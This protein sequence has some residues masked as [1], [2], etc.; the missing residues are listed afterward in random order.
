MQLNSVNVRLYPS[1]FRGNNFNPEAKLNTEEN[2]TS[3]V[4]RLS[5]RDGFVLSNTWV[6][7][8][9]GIDN[10]NT[11]IF[12]LHGY[13]FEISN[14]ASTLNSFS[15]KTSIY[16]HIRVGSM[17]SGNPDTG[18]TGYSA[19]VLT[20]I[21][22]GASTDPG[23]NQYAPGDVLD[24][25][26]DESDESY[27]FIGLELIDSLEGISTSSEDFYLL[28]LSRAST[29]DVWSVPTSSSIKFDLVD[30]SGGQLG[31]NEELS[32]ASQLITEFVKAKSTVITNLTDE[33]IT[34]IPSGK[35]L[36]SI[37]F[38]NNSN[39]YAEVTNTDNTITLQQYSSGKWNNASIAS[40]PVPSA[41][42]KGY[43]YQDPDTKILT[44][45]YFDEE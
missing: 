4:S 3:L 38:N 32:L 44:L 27:T 7:S 34:S 26:Q 10:S 17:N 30:I 33:E 6:S 41:I 43:F 35:P 11:F 45:Y 39:T 22:E 31:T 14:L 15:T 2:I 24:I 16:A 9:G 19:V 29:S 37:I 23:S 1:A 25:A 20:G 8:T 13:I 40:T 36:Q 5:S 21:D 12:S 28:L 42:S 18:N